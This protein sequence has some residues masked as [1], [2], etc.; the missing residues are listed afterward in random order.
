[1]ILVVFGQDLASESVIGNIF[2][3]WLMSALIYVYCVIY[4]LSPCSSSSSFLRHLHLRILL[5]FINQLILLLLLPF[6]FISSSSKSSTASP[7]LL[8]LLLLLFF[9][10]IIFFYCFILY[11]SS[12]S[13]SPI[14]FILLLPLGISNDTVS[15]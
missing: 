1:M 13:S 14:T 10:F 11:S 7:F 15:D 8:H 4:F 9:L 6:F 3:Y 5:R 12:S 2:L